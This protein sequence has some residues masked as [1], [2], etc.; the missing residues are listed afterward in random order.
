MIEAYQQEEELKIQEDK[1]K[2][3]LSQIEMQEIDKLKSI[4]PYM[5]NSRPICKIIWESYYRDKT[6]ELLNRLSKEKAIG[7]YKITCLT[8]NKIYIGQSVNIQDRLIQHI[9]AGCG[10]D[11]PANNKLYKAMQELGLSNFSFV[12][13]E[14]CDQSKLNEREKFY[15]DY[16]NSQIWGF[17]ETKGGAKGV[18]YNESNINENNR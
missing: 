16:Y 2:L 15:I 17:N 4:I 3:I 11:A 14:Q 5:R 1:Y 12:I 8:D 9:K 7:I 6:N 13:L 10:I 18:S